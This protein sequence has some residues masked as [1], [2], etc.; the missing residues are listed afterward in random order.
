MV[1]LSKQ[2]I[3][4]IRKITKEIP[5]LKEIG[6][7]LDGVDLSFGDDLDVLID[8]NFRDTYVVYEV[9][10]GRGVGEEF[11]SFSFYYNRDPKIAVYKAIERAKKFVSRMFHKMKQVPTL[12]FNDPQQVDPPQTQEENQSITELLE[13]NSI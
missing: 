2:S 8:F 10:V 3:A 4:E 12:E 6:V 9:E 1:N 13:Q 7:E 11:D 5:G